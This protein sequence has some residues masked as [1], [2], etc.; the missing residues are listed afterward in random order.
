ML[1]KEKNR[2]LGDRLLAAQLNQQ[3]TVH[4]NI[5]KVRLSMS[6]LLTVVNERKALREKYR[7]FL[8]D[9]YIAER[10]KEEIRARLEAVRKILTKHELIHI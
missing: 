1:L 9:Q 4:N 10:K 6:R 8:E 7:K 5:K 2:L 3:F